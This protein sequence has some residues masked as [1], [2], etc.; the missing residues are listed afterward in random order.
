LGD[1]ASATDAAVQDMT[2][3]RDFLACYDYGMGGVW[4][5]ISANSIGQIAQKYPKLVAVESRP[6]WMTDDIYDRIASSLRC[7][8]DDPPQGWFSGMTTPPL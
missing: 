3:K 7:D 4:C 6:A 1:T 8:I 2:E 5:L